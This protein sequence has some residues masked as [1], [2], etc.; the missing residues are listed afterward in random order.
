[1]TKPLYASLQEIVLGAVELLTPAER[2]NVA[3]FAAKY[4]YVKNPG[5]YTGKWNNAIAPYMIDPMDALTSIYH[6]AV[7]MVAPA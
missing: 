2:L 6:D 7:I 5:A 1:M 4:R 3:A